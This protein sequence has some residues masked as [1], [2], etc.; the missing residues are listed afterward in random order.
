[1]CTYLWNPS[2]V[3]QDVSKALVAAVVEPNEG[4]ISESLGRSQRVQLVNKVSCLFNQP[5]PL[6]GE[7]KYY[8]FY[9]FFKVFLRVFFSVHSIQQWALFR[10]VQN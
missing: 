8:R 5:N 1:M 9:T 6:N 4:L 10:I 2:P 3:K 7:P